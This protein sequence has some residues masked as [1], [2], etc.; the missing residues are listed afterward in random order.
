MREIAHT[1]HPHPSSSTDLE[2]P[3]SASHILLLHQVKNAYRFY[4]STSL[5][6]FFHSLVFRRGACV[7]AFSRPRHIH[8]TLQVLTQLAMEHAGSDLTSPGFAAQAVAYVVGLG[9]FPIYVDSECR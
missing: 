5:R 8:P 7:S 1:P 9:L 2:G 4:L 6:T 3:E